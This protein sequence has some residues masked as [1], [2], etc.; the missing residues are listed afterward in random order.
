MG[1]RVK[2]QPAE[3]EVDRGVEMLA[4]AVPAGRDTD[5]LDARVQAFRAGVADPVCEVGHQPGLV[6]FEGAGRVD[7]GLQP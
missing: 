6:S 4:I 1:L 5:R 7:H 2:L 3:V